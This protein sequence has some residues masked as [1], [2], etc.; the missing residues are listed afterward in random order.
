MGF[1]FFTAENYPSVNPLVVGIVKTRLTSFGASGIASFSPL[2]VRYRG[3][4][5]VVSTVIVIGL[6][7]LFCSVMR[8]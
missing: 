7:S 4:N 5:R 3:N 6:F 1:N 2:V 8:I